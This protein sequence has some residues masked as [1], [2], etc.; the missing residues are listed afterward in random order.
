MKFWKRLWWNMAKT[1]GHELHRCFTASRANSA[2]L[3]GSNGLTRASKRPN[4]VVRRRRS[5]FIWRSWCRRSGE[6]LLLLLGALLHSV[7]SI[8]NIYCKLNVGLCWYMQHCNK[9]HTVVRIISLSE[10]YFMLATDHR[11]HIL[12]LNIDSQLQW[13]FPYVRSATNLM[14]YYD[15]E[16]YW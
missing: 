8:T 5:C 15:H 10:Q 1:N 13:Q 6:Q 14:S 7:W 4:G 9:Q 2:R 12:F 11:H 16:M 3:V